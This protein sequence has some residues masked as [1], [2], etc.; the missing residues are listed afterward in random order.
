[1][2]ET[3]TVPEERE[4]IPQESNEESDVDTRDFI[5]EYMEAMRSRTDA[6]EEFQEA[7]A[8]F[9]ISTF[10]GRRWLFKSLPD[11]PFFSGGEEGSKPMGRL[12]NVWFKLLGKSRI[13][14]KTSTFSPAEEAIR[15]LG[16]DLLLPHISTPEYLHTEMAKKVKGGECHCTWVTDECSGFYSMLKNVIHTWRGWMRCYRNL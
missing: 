6:P 7:V 11:M 12:L 14:R 3:D 16:K 1:M 8:Y 5:S 15:E 4:T 13:T 9:L 2:S 10:A